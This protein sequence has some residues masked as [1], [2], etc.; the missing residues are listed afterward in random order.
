MPI[1]I[2]A[3]VIGIILTTAAVIPLVNSYVDDT[4]DVYNN[5]NSTVS[6]LIGDSDYTITIDGTTYALEINDV[7]VT[8]TAQIGLVFTD[9]FNIVYNTSSGSQLFSSSDIAHTPIT[10]TGDVT[11]E[12][13]GSDVTITYGTSTPQTEVTFEIEWGYIYDLTGDYGMYRLYNTSKT[14]YVNS[15]DDICGANVLGTTSDWFIYEG[16][17]VRT[18]VSEESTTATYTL[19]E[20]SGYNDLYTLSVGSNGSYAFVVDNN[21]SDYTVHPWIVIAPLEVTGHKPGSEYNSLI[22][23]LPMMAFIMLVVAAAAMIY[24]KKD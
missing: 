19:T 21:G 2:V 10:M 22:A 9:L 17:N 5:T 6:K 1:L 3:L 4:T 15:I 13:S 11:I 12:I 8:P 24:S 14:I 20:V 7:D 18:L 23:I 16:A